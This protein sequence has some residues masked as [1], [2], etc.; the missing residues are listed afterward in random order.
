MLMLAKDI[1]ETHSI[2]HW[3]DRV[4]AAVHERRLLSSIVTNY[5]EEGEICNTP[6]E[7]ESAKEMDWGGGIHAAFLLGPCCQIAGDGASLPHVL[8]H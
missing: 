3:P 2:S 7:C 8:W 4:A 6:S 5:P 1:W